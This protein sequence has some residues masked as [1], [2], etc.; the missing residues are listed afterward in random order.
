MDWWRKENMS[1][2]TKIVILL[3]AACLSLL[4]FNLIA[5]CGCFSEILK[6]GRG[7]RYTALAAPSQVQPD[8][9]VTASLKP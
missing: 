5:S 7:A 1:L 9:V 2:K 4:E 6:A 8:V 3:V